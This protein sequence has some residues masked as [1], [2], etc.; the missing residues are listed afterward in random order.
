M[1]LNVI[2]DILLNIFMG[3]SSKI[4]LCKSMQTC[5]DD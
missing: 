3:I 2:F 1:M 5:T 4:A